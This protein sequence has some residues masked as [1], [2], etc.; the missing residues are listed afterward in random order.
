MT[1]SLGSIN[2]LEQLTELRKTLTY[3]Y[4][5]IIGLINDIDEQLA[6]EIHGVRS[7]R[8]PSTGASVTM[9]LGVRCPPGTWMCSPTW[10]VSEPH[11]SG[12]FMEASSRRHDQLLTPFPALLPTLEKWSWG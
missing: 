5:F 10:K 11:T 8:V 3:I 7:E 9:E 2:L 12:I 1:P 4:Q 6:E